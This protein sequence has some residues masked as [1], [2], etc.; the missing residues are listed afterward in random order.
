MTKK[1]AR[2]RVRKLLKAYWSA[3]KMGDTWYQKKIEDE[4][5]AIIYKVGVCKDKVKKI[6][7]MTLKINKGVL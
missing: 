6:K 5:L 4:I 3:V 7:G 1:E 2:Q